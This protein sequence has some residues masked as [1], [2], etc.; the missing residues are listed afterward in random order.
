MHPELIR[1]WRPRSFLEF[2]G[3]KNRQTIQIFQDALLN[4]HRPPSP[5][6]IVSPFGYG[7]T[8]FARLLIQ[9]ICCENR[10]AATADPCRLCRQC[11]YHGPKYDWGSGFPRHFEVDCTS[12]KDATLIPLLQDIVWDCDTVTFLDELHRLAPRLQEALLKPVEDCP[13]IL[14]AAV[15]ADR[16]GELA[17]PLRERFEKIEFV[18]PSEAEMVDFY[19]VRIKE[20]GVQA[21]REL[22]ELMVGRSSRSFRTCQKALAAAAATSQ[23]TLTTRELERFVDAHPP[24][25]LLTEKSI[26]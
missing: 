11:Q 23:R 5:A 15:M 18:T 21:D 26:Y 7:K 13:G 25:E 1:R 24:K 17:P 19:A 4:S 20:W 9:A 12:V 8:S 16:Y 14:F 10:N 6:L 3:A 2:A 22:L